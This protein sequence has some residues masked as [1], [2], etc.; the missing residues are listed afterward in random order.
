MSDLPRPDCAARGSEPIG[1]TGA[2]DPGIE[3]MFGLQ[4]NGG[5]CPESGRGVDEVALCIKG[6]TEAVVIERH[7]DTGLQRKAEFV[8]QI[9]IGRAKGCSVRADFLVEN[10]EI[11]GARA[12]IRFEAIET[13]EMIL[14]RDR[15]RQDDNVIDQRRARKRA[16]AVNLVWGYAA[17]RLYREVR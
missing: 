1:E 12:D 3:F 14:C 16:F 10:K 15:R 17:D 11:G 4:G 13:G 6:K 9:C 5:A 8:R 2:D 7:I